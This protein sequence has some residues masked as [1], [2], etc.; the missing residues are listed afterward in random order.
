VTAAG[1]YPHANHQQAS[2][3]VRSI[4]PSR[5]EGMGSTCVC[6]WVIESL[7]TASVGDPIIYHAE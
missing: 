1:G 3:A 6:A 7:Y 4:G 5:T 2:E